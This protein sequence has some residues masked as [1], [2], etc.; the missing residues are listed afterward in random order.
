MRTLIQREMGTALQSYDALLCPAAST[1]AYRL[2]E[3]ASDPLAMY[4][5]EGRALRT[6]LFVGVGRQKVVS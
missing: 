3:K 4:K 6:V 1:P 2:G 5:G